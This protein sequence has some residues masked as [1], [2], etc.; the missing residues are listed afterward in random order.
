MILQVCPGELLLAK[1]D[2]APIWDSVET[3]KCDDEHFKTTVGDVLISLSASFKPIWS[4]NHSY[5]LT[6][7]PRRLR[8]G[9]ISTK[10]VTRVHGVKKR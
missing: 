8:L 5:F 7:V 3:G 4:V 9:W 1:S 6:L 10:H 2:G